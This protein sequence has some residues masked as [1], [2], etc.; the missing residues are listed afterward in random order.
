M[1]AEGKSSWIINKLQA[2]PVD[3]Y[4]AL[5]IIIHNIYKGFTS[6]NLFPAAAGKCSLII[7]QLKAPPV[8]FLY[9]LSVVRYEQSDAKITQEC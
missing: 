8:D 5:P 4:E 6:S 3:F 7:N 2:L 9:L 1:A